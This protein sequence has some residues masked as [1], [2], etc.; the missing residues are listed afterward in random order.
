MKTLVWHWPG[1]SWPPSSDNENLYVVDGSQP[2]AVQMSTASV[3]FEKYAIANKDF[4]EVLY[5]PKFINKTGVGCVIDE[6]PEE[7]DSALASG[8]L[9]R[10]R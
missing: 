2:A 4:T 8:R 10:H 5:R 7:D 1:S 6:L 3:D 9:N